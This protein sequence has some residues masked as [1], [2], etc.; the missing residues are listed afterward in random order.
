MPDAVSGETSGNYK[1]HDHGLQPGNLLQ[2][3]HSN[4]GR[5]SLR[6]YYE[7]VETLEIWRELYKTFHHAAVQSVTTLDMN[8]ICET[9]TLKISQALT[10]HCPTNA[11]QALPLLQA[12]QNIIKTIPFSDI[13]RQSLKSKT[14]FFLFPDRGRTSKPTSYITNTMNLIV[15]MAQLFSMYEHSGE[16]YNTVGSLVMNCLESLFK[17]MKD[18]SVAAAVPMVSGLSD[19]ILCLLQATPLQDG[20][21]KFWNESL[22]RMWKCYFT[23]IETYVPQ[24]SVK[25]FLGWMSTLLEVGFMHSDMEIRKVTIEFWDSIVVPAFTLDKTTVPQ[26]LKEARE[27][28]IIKTNEMPNLDSDV[29]VDNSSLFSRLSIF[30]FADLKLKRNE[31]I[32]KISKK[33][34]QSLVQQLT[35]KGHILTKHQKE[36]FRR[37]KD[38]IPALYSSALQPAQ[39]DSIMSESSIDTSDFIAPQRIVELPASTSNSGEF[40]EPLTPS[41]KVLEPP[42][43]LQRTAEYRKKMMID[44]EGSIVLASFDDNLIHEENAMAEPFNTESNMPQIEESAEPPVTPVSL[45]FVT[46]SVDPTSNRKLNL[47]TVA[48]RIPS[49]IIDSNKELPKQSEEQIVH[50]SEADIS[51]TTPVPISSPITVSSIETPISF[52]LEEP[53][54]CSNVIMESH[55]ATQS[56]SL[57]SE[58]HMDVQEVVELP[59]TP[60]TVLAENT[61]QKNVTVVPKSTGLSGIIPESGKLLLSESCK[62]LSSSSLHKHKKKSG[63]TLTNYFKPVSITLTADEN[64]VEQTRKGGARTIHLSIEPVIATTAVCSSTAV[65]VQPSNDVSDI[66]PTIIEND[67]EI[68]E[69]SSMS[70]VEVSTTTMEND[71]SLSPLKVVVEKVED[72]SLNKTFAALETMTPTFN[73]ENEKVSPQGEASSSSRRKAK[74]PLRRSPQDPKLPPFKT[75]IKQDCKSKIEDEVSSVGKSSKSK[76]LENEKLPKSGR[77]SSRGRKSNKTSKS[78]V[79][80]NVNTENN[81]SMN[82]SSENVSPSLLQAPPKRKYKSRKSKSKLSDIAEDLKAIKEGSLASIETSNTLDINKG[83][84]SSSKSEI[85]VESINTEKQNL[86]IEISDTVND[87]H[88]EKETVKMLL[89]SSPIIENEAKIITQTDSNKV[90]EIV[91]KGNDTT[92]IIENEAKIITQTDSNKQKEIV[93]KGNDTTISVTKNNPPKKDKFSFPKVKLSP[94]KEK[95]TP[96]TKS[97]ASGVNDSRLRNRKSTNFDTTFTPSKTNEFIIKNKSPQVVLE[98][99]NSDDFKISKHIKSLTHFE[100]SIK[101]STK[102]GESLDKTKL[103]DNVEEISLNICDALLSKHKNPTSKPVSTTSESCKKDNFEDQNKLAQDIPEPSDPKLSRH[104]KSTSVTELLGKDNSFVESKVTG[105]RGASPSISDPRL[106]RQKSVSNPDSSSS[107]TVKES[108]SGEAVKSAK[109]LETSLSMADSR[110]SRHRKS[111]SHVDS[112]YS[113]TA[114]ESESGDTIK[115]TKFNKSSVNMADPRLLR[116]K[117]SVSKLDSTSSEHEEKV[118]CTSEVK[119]VDV[120]K[121][122]ASVVDPRLLRHRKS[123]PNIDSSH[124][125]LKE[126][127]RSSIQSKS[128]DDVHE[129][130]ADSRTSRSRKTTSNPEYPSEPEDVECTSEVKSIDVPKVS[131]SIEDSRLLRHR[132]SLSNIDSSHSEL[133]EKERSS[134]QSKSTD[135]VHE[136]IADSRTSRHEN[137]ADSR[138]SRSRKTTSIPDYPSE[139]EENVECSSEVKSIDVPKVSASIEDPRLLRHRKSL[140]N[141]DS[142]RSELKEKDRSSIQSKSTDK[143]HEN[144]ADSRTSRSRKTTSIPEYPSE[145]EE[146]V[147]CTSEVKSI[148]VPKV[149]ASIEDPRLLRHR[150]SLPNIDSSH[151]ELKEKDRSSIQD[152]STNNVHENIADSR[153]S[154]S[155]KTTSIPEY[156]SEPEENVECTSE[157]KSIDVPKDSASIED[158]RLLRHRKSLPNI[159]SSHSELKEKDRSSIQS[160]SIDKIHENIADS[161][162]SRS[163]KTT[164]IPECPSEPEENVECTSEVKSI[165]VPKVSASIEDPRLLRHRKSL[166]NIDSSQSEL[167]EKDRSSIQSKSTDNIH[168]NI[169]DSRTSR[170]RKSTS[171]PEYSTS[172]STHKDENPVQ[173]KLPDFRELSINIGDPRH[174]RHRKSM[175]NFGSITSASHNKG[176]KSKSKKSG[177]ISDLRLSR[178]RK[179]VDKRKTTEIV[180]NSDDDKSKSKAGNLV[181]VSADIESNILTSRRLR[182]KRKMDKDFINIEDF[183]P[184]ERRRKMSDTDSDISKN[185]SSN[186]ANEKLTKLS[187]T[188]TVGDIQK[189]HAANGCDLSETFDD[190]EKELE[191]LTEGSQIDKTCPEKE[192]S[193]EKGVERTLRKKSVFEDKTHNSKQSLNVLSKRVLSSTVYKTSKKTKDDSLKS[194]LKIVPETQSENLETAAGKEQGIPKLKKSKESGFSNINLDDQLS[195]ATVDMSETFDESSTLKQNSNKVSRNYDKLKEVSYNTSGLKENIPPIEEVSDDVHSIPDSLDIIESSQEST[196]S[197]SIV[198]HPIMQNCSVAVRR[199]DTI[200]EP[201]SKIDM[202]QG[203]HKLMI[204]VPEDPGSPYKLL[205]PEKCQENEAKLIS[206]SKLLSVTKSLIGTLDTV[207]ENAHKSFRKTSL[208]NQSKEEESNEK[209]LLNK[210]KDNKEEF[211][212][213]EVSIIKEDVSRSNSRRRINHKSKERS[214]DNS[215]S[216]VSKQLSDYDDKNKDLSKFDT[217]KLKQISKS[218]DK[219][220]D[221]TKTDSLKPKHLPDSDNKMNDCGNF[222]PAKSKPRESLYSEEKSKDGKKSDTLKSKSKSLSETV[223]L[224]E[225]IIESSNS[226]TEEINKENISSEASKSKQSKSNSTLRSEDNAVNEITSKLQNKK[227][228]L[229]SDKTEG[230]AIPSDS[231]QSRSQDLNE[232]NKVDDSILHSKKENKNTVIDKFKVIEKEDKAKSRSIQKDKVDIAISDTTKSRSKSNV[233]KLD[234]TN[235]KSQSKI[236]SESKTEQSKIKYSVDVLC[237]KV[238]LASK[239]DATNIKTKET[240]LEITKPKSMQQPDSIGTKDINKSPVKDREKSD[241]INTIHEHD[242]KEKLKNSNVKKNKLHSSV[243]VTKSTSRT[244]KDMKKNVNIKDKT[245]SEDVNKTGNKIIIDETTKRSKSKEDS[246]FKVRII[247]ETNSKGDQS[248]VSQDPTSGIKVT[249][250]EPLVSL[251]SKRKEIDISSEDITDEDKSIEMVVSKIKRLAQNAECFIPKKVQSTITKK[252]QDVNTTPMKSSSKS[253]DSEKT[254]SPSPTRPILTSPS[255]LLKA[256]SSPSSGSLKLSH[257]NRLGRIEGRAQYMVGL[258]VGS[259]DTSLQQEELEVSSPISSKIQQDEESVKT[260][261]PVS[262]KRLLYTLTDDE[263]TPVASKLERRQD[264]SVDHETPVP[265]LRLSSDLPIKRVLKLTTGDQETPPSKKKRVWFPDPEVS[266][267]RVFTAYEEAESGSVTRSY[268]RTKIMLGLKRRD[269]KLRVSKLRSPILS[270]KKI[271]TPTN[272]VQCDT[273]S[274]SQSSPDLSGITSQGSVED[275]YTELLNSQDSFFPPLVSCMHPI[276]SIAHQLTTHVMW[277]K[278]LVV[279]L[280]RKGI[281]TVGDLSRLDEASINRLPVATPK[282]TRTREILENYFKIVGQGGEKGDANPNGESSFCTPPQAV[283]PAKFTLPDAVRFMNSRSSLSNLLEEVSNSNQ[284]SDR[285]NQEI[286]KILHNKDRPSSSSEKEESVSDTVAKFGRDIVIDHLLRTET[287]H[288]RPTSSIILKWILSNGIESILSKLPH[289]EFIKHIVKNNSEGLLKVLTENPALQEKFLQ[290][291][292]NFQLTSGQINHKDLFDRLFSADHNNT[293]L[294][295]MQSF[296]MLKKSTEEILH[297]MPVESVM[298]FATS[299]LNLVDK[300]GLCIESLITDTSMEVPVNHFQKLVLAVAKRVSSADFATIQYKV[301]MELLKKD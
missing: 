247:E 224:V 52:P 72:F 129:N 128:T 107:E 12:M 199:I 269:K 261:T 55:A 299:R 104:R 162:T 196:T 9:I 259:K 300:I 123:L 184:P 113:E 40:K 213:V 287:Q 18:A 112:S 164:L 159:D 227:Q 217:P 81:S 95:N 260:S 31:E 5:E 204:L 70:S 200:L 65:D 23:F 66:E 286:S 140:P 225:T 49:S 141:I 239:D 220:K 69:A 272:I 230:S 114:K 35:D 130:I 143:V 298:Q 67:N 289:S 109:L 173:K 216:D 33:T 85:N 245:E 41:L 15:K 106:L 48:I 249:L 102:S 179:S 214:Y 172:A 301:A 93:T 188:T 295:S 253:S 229:T 273:S 44:H 13:C 158:P 237:E 124:S 88:N 25:D 163:R 236:N 226:K 144:I 222:E 244:E 268:A 282:I 77:R 32:K 34:H 111:M 284:C 134:I 147:E 241:K 252:S 92:T 135:D 80:N 207:Q 16:W 189:D 206:N 182:T 87:N 276:E 4:S 117:K 218:D 175:S 53:S 50:N 201:G 278:A 142:S 202:S 211:S 262:R 219:T 234:D 157:V 61:S 28:C 20:T 45:A 1:P 100:S 42:S 118:E 126:K 60:L 137:I 75:Q 22:Q 105:N 127:D 277:T 76:K 232:I 165:D 233:S 148:D 178:C 180:S 47:E 79:E 205:T 271:V 280:N 174:S 99:C 176:E 119:S 151:S 132:K 38:D 131:A 257:K 91:S 62:S 153:T 46:N 82:I 275:V 212:D 177:I 228:D 156:P 161:R 191:A 248:E 194:D 198:K 8:E 192:R 120:P 246:S 7:T 39:E 264:S 58:S 193:S 133:K 181:P 256:F 195:E 94:A 254:P 121:V 21:I 190:I 29:A 115:S 6:E 186:T 250:K 210:E 293:L 296:L 17:N 89:D 101:E 274:Q 185:V 294:N 122:S 116:H 251:S 215:E 288:S 74:S 169:A 221:T 265:E 57:L 290:N 255:S 242:A 240:N 238:T 197:L 78:E 168:E 146:N 187:S 154:R 155:R 96:Q 36:V 145:P 51:V 263:I 149:S 3:H 110:L 267:T 2:D 56:S 11:N 26:A 19:S 170:S 183:M 171:N 64:E 281:R 167:K 37:H 160:K 30:S 166:P 27:K 209:K 139:P 285:L 83:L 84:T 270:A 54:V 103:S 125:E 86:P 266:G 108:D 138:T 235:S 97:G 10:K 14:R 223:E 231:K 136:N 63:N 279:E 291:Y 43:C 68:L 297:K 71:G 203:D 150:K 292:F 258:A 243:Q 90:K 24:K 208:R 98:P 152:K 73:I 59:S 283:E